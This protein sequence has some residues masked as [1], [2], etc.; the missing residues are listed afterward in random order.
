[1]SPRA[2]HPRDAPPPAPQLSAP[3]FP[4]PAVN[5]SRSSFS[6]CLLLALAFAAPVSAQRVSTADRL[7]AL[8]QQLSA[9]R[10]GNLDLLNQVGELKSEVQTL[11]AQIEELQ[12]QLEQ[13][14]Q[15]GRTQYLDLDGRLNRLE[16]AAPPATPAPVPATPPT[17]TATPA[18]PTVPAAPAVAAPPDPAPRVYGDASTLGRGM[19][20]RTAYNSAFDALKAGRYAESAR[21][22]QAFLETYPSGVFAPNAMYWLGESYYVT[23]NYA[24]AQEQFQG[25]LDQHPTHDKAAGALLKV[26]LCQYGL[27]QLDAAEATLARVLARYPGTEAARTADDRLRA[28]QL[29]RVR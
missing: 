1:M 27:R 21:A 5:I 3:R 22:F 19:D 15:S 25:L 26:G 14:K 8:E 12:Q 23:Q 20:E 10:T 16:N 24:L 18:R 9:M 13:Q 28:I 7:T 2:G 4:V 29:S 6:A 11:R 17:A